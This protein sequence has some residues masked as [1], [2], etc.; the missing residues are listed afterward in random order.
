VEVKLTRT[1]AQRHSYNVKLTRE[2]VRL[3]AH[4]SITDYFYTN[5]LLD[6]IKKEA[7]RLESR[8]QQ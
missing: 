2:E 3:I 6:L 1:P 8:E 4:D 7:E 5:K